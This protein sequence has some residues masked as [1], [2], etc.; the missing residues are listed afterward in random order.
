M[1]WYSHADPIVISTELF[2]R[3]NGLVS[4][5]FLNNTIFAALTTNL[6]LPCYGASG[7]GD[8]KWKSTVPPIVGYLSEDSASPYYSV[9]YHG[10]VATL[11]VYSYSTLNGSFTCYSEE[12]GLPDEASVT[13]HIANGLLLVKSITLYFYNS[14][15]PAVDV[16]MCGDSRAEMPY[17]L[18]LCGNS[19]SS[20]SCNV[21]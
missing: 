21:C 7:Y 3:N 4:G 1:V 15:L 14:S 2:Q 13:V 10:S 6:I 11:T 5:K 19:S 9:Q 8:I 18:S 16:C 12:A 20:S 17:P